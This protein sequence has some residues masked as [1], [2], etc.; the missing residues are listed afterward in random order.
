MATAG[1]AFIPKQK[2]KYIIYLYD[3]THQ[4]NVKSVR[5]L[6]NCGNSISGIKRIRILA[7]GVWGESQSGNMF[8][9][10]VMLDA[11]N[12]KQ[13]VFAK[14]YPFLLDECL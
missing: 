5:V 11:I 8:T 13:T 7:A 1:R 9:N 14:H 3:F 10:I 2:T 4:C 6:F 12:I